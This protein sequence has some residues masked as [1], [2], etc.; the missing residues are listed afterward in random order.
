MKKKWVIGRDFDT[1]SAEMKEFECPEVVLEIKPIMIRADR[2]L[3]GC[4]IPAMPRMTSII[5]GKILVTRLAGNRTEI[6]AYDIQPWV[7]P[8]LIS[9]IEYISIGK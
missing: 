9:L 1:I 5:S 8:Y 4:Y 6:Q 2:V 7:E 3:F